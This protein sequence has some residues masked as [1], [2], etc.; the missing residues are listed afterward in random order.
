MLVA[1]VVAHLITAVV[2]LRPVLGARVAVVVAVNT[3]TILALSY[4]QQPQELQIQVLAAVAAFI[5]QTAKLVVRVLSSS[6]MQI[7]TQMQHQPLEAQHL[8]TRA[9]IKFIHGQVPVQLL[10][11][12]NTWHILHNLVMTT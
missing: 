3:T 11:K 12:E 5:Q 8:P 2:L 1:A 9:G 10:S 6:V 4:K 7:L